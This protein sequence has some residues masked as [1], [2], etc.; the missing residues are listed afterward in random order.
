[1]ITR[2]LFLASL[3]FVLA[4]DSP[5]QLEDWVRHDDQNIRTFHV[6]DSIF[7]YRGGLVLQAYSPISHQWSQMLTGG[8]FV[9]HDLHRDHVLVQEGQTFYAFASRA[10]TGWQTLL[11]TAGASVATDRTSLASV[12]IDGNTAHVFGAWT[13]Q[14]SSHTFA[15]PPSVAIDGEV[16]VVGDASETFAIAAHF[17]TW[18]PAPSGS[19]AGQAAHGRVGIVLSP[20]NVHLFSAST[21]TW[22]TLPVGGPISVHA[23]DLAGYVAI[24]EGATWHFFSGHNGALTS[25]S[26]SATNGFV[27]KREVAVLRESASRVHLYSAPQ[28]TIRTLDSPAGFPTVVAGDFVALV[29]DGTGTAQAFSAARGELSALLT[30]GHDFQVD[31]GS[32]IVAT[33]VGGPEPS[34]VYSAVRNEWVPA[35]AI[36]NP[37]VHQLTSSVVLEDPAGGLYGLSAH[38]DAWTFV[39]AP[40]SDATWAA[41]ACFV[42][43]SGTR[44][45]V[46]SVRANTWKQLI[47]LL[48]VTDVHIAGGVVL[49]IEGTDLYGFSQRLGRWSQ[50]PKRSSVG[51]LGVSAGVAFVHDFANVH[52]YSGYGQVSSVAD[53][54]EGPHLW[55]RGG[56]G[57][58]QVSAEPSAWIFLLLGTRRI[59]ASNPY[60][61]LRIDPQ[62]FV[63]PLVNLGNAPESGIVD[64]SL[65]APSNPLLTGRTFLAQV[66]VFPSYLTDADQVTFF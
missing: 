28:G 25:V 16:T 51:S 45:D 56:P 42:A 11:T 5:A 22:T 26:P 63:M 14:W 49:A 34:F 52:V 50:H 61:T 48:P 57:R 32:L 7:F 40:P 21:N 19:F 20:G 46:F 66:L 36:A 62:S 37:I 18:E 4:P 44:L 24:R 17:G 33:P 15:G 55:T 54:P 39:D 30:G 38:E 3:I 10:G 29:E 58:I 35:P 65:R 47:T 41:G 23:R 59:E 6:D 9:T 64:V 13:G 43:R 8:G 27:T 31:D 53:Y 60:G 2:C 1:M 12:V